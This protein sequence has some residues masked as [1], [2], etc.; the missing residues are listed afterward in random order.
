MR[1]LRSDQIRKAASALLRLAAPPAA[2]LL[3]SLNGWTQ[4][5]ADSLPQCLKVKP[6][7]VIQPN[8]P[9][10]PPA[11]LSQISSQIYWLLRSKPSARLGF[12]GLQANPVQMDALLAE[13]Y[14]A[15]G[16]M[17][18]WLGLD[19]L[20][21]Q[22]A[23]ELLALLRHADEDGLNPARYRIADI[24]ALLAA[25][26]NEDL[27]RLDLLLT[28]AM[29]AYITDMRKGAAASTH[30]DLS[31][32]AAVRES[33]GDVP[34][35]LKEGLRTVELRR[36][37]ER[38]A[39]QH[40]AYRTLKGLL[41]SRRKIEAAQGEGGWPKLPD[42]KKIEPGM[43]DER[44]SLL[45]Q[46]LVS[47][48]DLRTLPP[49]VY[50]DSPKRL[51]IYDSELVK[52]VKRFQARHNMEQDGVVGKT[53]LAALNSP[54]REQIRKI[55]LSLERWRWLPHQLNGRRIVVNIAGFSLTVMQDEQTELAMP[56]IV[57][58]DDHQTPIF[59]QD[60]SYIELNPYWN[61]PQS[62]ARKEIVE[63]MKKDPSYLSRQRI[64][65]FAGWGSGAPEVS[66]AAINWQTIGAGINRYRLRQEPGK[67]NALGTVKFV[68]P[69]RSSV[70]MHDT[71][72]RNLFQQTRRSLSHGCIR[73]SQ[74]FELTLHLLQSDGWNVSPERLKKEIASQKP[75][76]YVLHK[77]VPV[78]IL[79]LTAVV[80]EDG[81]AHFYEDIYG[82]D[83][84]LAAALQ[85]DSPA[86]FCWQ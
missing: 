22:R 23:D 56:V 18:H 27:A 46:R 28:A 6:Q 62:I 25:K 16:F 51:R 71:P 80:A 82:N 3:F 21:R 54:G 20:D 36:F 50:A 64:R 1:L 53:T 61:V 14:T 17:P 66:P 73:V 81:S 31:L 67:G 86:G 65:I 74:P 55:I 33:G 57:G 30:F 19:G 47:S 12:V 4:Q 75:Q 8:L 83:A 44:L 59:S 29:S 26:K 68:F 58:Q 84:Q 40:Q 38:Q 43:T 37:L 45:A 76:S 9:L 10:I 35:I 32:L 48:G 34:N 7:A 39:P 52:G 41:A 11:G 79:Y 63:K 42:G 85:L 5:T 60:M 15:S 69:N 24:S 49:P 77:P 72:G 78:H 2:V 13:L 70:Y